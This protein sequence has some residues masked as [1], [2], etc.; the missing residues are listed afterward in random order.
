MLAASPITI[1]LSTFPSSPKVSISVR[2]DTAFALAESPIAK[3]LLMTFP[4]ARIER[5]FPASEKR[6]RKLSLQMWVIRESFAPAAFHSALRPCALPKAVIALIFPVSDI[7]MRRLSLEMS[8]DTAL[9]AVS[10]DS[11]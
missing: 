1:A 10:A 4:K 11:L 8:V 2:P 3:F 6:T 9:F 7:D 5:I